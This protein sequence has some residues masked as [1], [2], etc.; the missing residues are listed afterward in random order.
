MSTSCSSPRGA[1]ALIAGDHERGLRLLR[2]LL[3]RKRDYPGLLDQLASAYGA[4]SPG[5]S[6]SASSPRDGDSS[7]SWRRW[8]PSIRSSATCASGS[9]PVARKRIEDGES[10]G[11]AASAS[12]PWSRPCGSGR[13]SRAPRG[14][15]ARRFEDLPTLD[16]AVSDVPHPVGPWVRSPADARVSRLLYRP[17]L[18]ADSE[19]A[20]QGKVPGQLAASLESSDLGRR[21]IFRTAP[22]VTGPTARGRSPAVDVA[23]A[24]IDRSDPNSLKFQARWADL[25]RTGRV[26]RRDSRGDPAEAA[27]AQAGC[28]VRLAGRP[29]ARRDRRP[30][31]HAPA[32]APARHRRPVSLP[33]LIR[34]G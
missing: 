25:A 2:E 15:T 22:G 31:R 7:T 10:A 18:A 8:L 9:S 11:A 1:T 13:R 24:L 23:R 27:P 17:I 26:D 4:G 29:G 28:L 6:S 32:G 30:G 14:S 5:P 33:V 16:V 34:P 12:T 21:L 3:A 20:R 19:E